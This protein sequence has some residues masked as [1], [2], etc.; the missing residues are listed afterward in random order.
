MSETFWLNDPTVLMNKKYM[1]R[2]WPQVGDTFEQKLNSV[3]RLV[4]LLSILGYLLTSSLKLLVSGVVTLVVLVVVYK[5]QHGKRV[6]QKLQTAMKEGFTNPD[7]YS[8]TKSHFTQPTVQN[9]LMNVQLPEIKYNPK[10]KIAAP[11]FNPAVENEINE[12]VKQSLDKRLFQNL[13]DSINFD[14]SMRGFYTTANTQIPNDQR[15]FA[16]F[17]YGDM[18]SCKEADAI[19]CEK[20]NYRYTTPG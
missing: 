11:S 12:S 18:K 19:Q 16:E 4:I 3:T 15:G 5:T 7:L 1:T 9:P 13:G 14:S 2:V 17:C 6:N 10:R 20:K 8:I